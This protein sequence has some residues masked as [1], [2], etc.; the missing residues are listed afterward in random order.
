MV[1]FSADITDPP[2]FSTNNLGG[3]ARNWVGYILVAGLMFV[4]LGVAQSTV[5]PA[6][7]GLLE[8]VTGADTGQ[9]TGPIQFG[10][11]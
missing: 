1:S 10:D 3:T 9:N 4:A 11:P 8:S 2:S 5:A 7:G 6:V